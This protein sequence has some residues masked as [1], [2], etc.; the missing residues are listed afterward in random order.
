MIRKPKR[1]NTR[2]IDG[3]KEMCYKVRV[4]DGHKCQMPNCGQRQKLQVHHV[5]RYA[6]S[7]YGRLNPDN[8]ILLCS[9]CH[10]DI[11]TGK[12]EIYAPLFVRIIGENTI[13]QNKKNEKN[14]K[15]N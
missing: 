10:K 15:D 8:C 13:K 4:R 7:S 6:D 5:I 14:A 12:E 9:R 3:Y 11:V 2:E 1:Y